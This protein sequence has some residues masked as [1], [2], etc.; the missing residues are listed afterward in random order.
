MSR[1][2]RLRNHTV[3]VNIEVDDW[4]V[5][6]FILH[7]DSREDAESQAQEVMR[8]IEKILAVQEPAVGK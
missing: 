4:Q 1:N 3:T 6:R 7:V 2:G 5:I 8:S